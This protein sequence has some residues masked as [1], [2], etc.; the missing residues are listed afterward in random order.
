MVHLCH[1]C[2]DE[3]KAPVFDRTTRLSSQAF[4]MT[5]GN[6]AAI[7]GANAGAVM[8]VDMMP[9]RS[10]TASAFTFSLI[11]AKIAGIQSIAA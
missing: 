6:P 8:R 1:G 9:N 3:K 10:A 5:F 2:S 4:I 11:S 7:A